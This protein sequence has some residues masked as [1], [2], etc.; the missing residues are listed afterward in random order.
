MESAGWKTLGNGILRWVGPR[1]LKP[2]S[3]TPRKSH[4]AVP[5]VHSLQVQ[6]CLP[7]TPSSQQAFFLPVVGRQENRRRHFQAQHKLH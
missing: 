3:L 1:P 4:G 5:L 7:E 6:S 2:N